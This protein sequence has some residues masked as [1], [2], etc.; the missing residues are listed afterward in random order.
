MVFVRP[1]ESPCKHGGKND[2]AEGNDGNVFRKHLEIEVG[3]R[4]VVDDDKK[5]KEAS[6]HIY[7]DNWDCS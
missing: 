1:E 7:S 2:H 6:R 4:S 3:I 5:D